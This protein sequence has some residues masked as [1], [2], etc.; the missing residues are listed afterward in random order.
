[1]VRRDLDG[2]PLF[3][4]RAMKESKREQKRYVAGDN[5]PCLIT[6]WDVSGYI[7]CTLKSDAHVSRAISAST[8]KRAL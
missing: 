8:C 7:T 1:M 2:R 3:Q 4:K 5:R 6:R